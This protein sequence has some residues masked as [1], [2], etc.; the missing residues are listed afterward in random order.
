[1][2]INQLPETKTFAPGYDGNGNVLSLTD[3]D[4]GANVA[5]YEYGP[6]GELI[7][8]DGLFAQVN[9][10][11]FS[12]KYQDGESDLLYYG[13]RYYSAEMGRWLSRDP[14]R[15][16]GGVN[17]YSFVGNEPIGAST[18]SAGNDSFSESTLPIGILTRRCFGD[19]FRDLETG[20]VIWV[21]QRLI[22]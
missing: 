3:L 6:F 15:E 13:Y 9:P 17:L 1:M 7:R 5:T 12:T 20:S 19:T 4:D 16:A 11:R 18:S 8:S 2:L 21:M 10:I 22:L 14:I